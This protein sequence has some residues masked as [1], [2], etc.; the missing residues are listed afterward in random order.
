MVT[1]FFTLSIFTG[2]FLLF[3]VQPMVG[4]LLLPV[5]GGTP[6]VWTVCML[7][8]QMML[9][10]GYLYAEKTLRYLGCEKQSVLHMLFMTAGIMMLPINI[11]TSTA[12]SV[13]TNPASWLITRLTVSIGFLFLMIS[14]NAPLL[15]RYYS[16]A[17]QSDSHD[18]YFLYAASNAGSFLAL[19][20]YPF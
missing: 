15:Q 1:A 17:G 14:A 10:G 8:F 3:L 19:L 5:M 4:K 11:D 6:A 18:P 13:V 20:S 2:S 16:Q 7:F 12:S 9:L